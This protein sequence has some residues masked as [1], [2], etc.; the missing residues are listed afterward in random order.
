MLAQSI[1]LPLV[2]LMQGSLGALTPRCK[3]VDGRACVF[4][5]RYNGALYNGCSTV[6]DTKLWCSTKTDSDDD[7]AQGGNSVAY[8]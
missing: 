2:L 8:N 4:P 3:T 1:L 6:D 5:F 7:H